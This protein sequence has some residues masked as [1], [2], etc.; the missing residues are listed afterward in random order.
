MISLNV[1]Q[2]SFEYYKNKVTYWMTFNEFNNQ[3]NYSLDLV[4]FTSSGFIEKDNREE[5]IYQSSHYELVISEKAVMIG[6]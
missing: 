3:A 2:N 6:H 4:T 5:F 1:S